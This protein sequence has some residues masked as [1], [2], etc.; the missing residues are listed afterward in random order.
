M[1]HSPSNSTVHC[2]TSSSLPLRKAITGCF[3]LQTAGEKC[4]GGALSKKVDKGFI[5]PSAMIKLMFRV[6]ERD[7]AA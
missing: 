7:A 5:T 4:S 1:S 3:E 2:S 6:K